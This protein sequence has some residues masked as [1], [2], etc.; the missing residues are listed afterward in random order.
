[1]IEII[2]DGSHVFLSPTQCTHTHTTGPEY[3]AKHRSR[4]Q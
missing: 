2:Y 4:T 1:L 3:A